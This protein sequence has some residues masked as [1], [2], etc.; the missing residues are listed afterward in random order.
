MTVFTSCITS[1]LAPYVP[2]TENPWN[3]VR[4]RHAF[5]RI[6]YDANR[7]MI[8]NALT[9][10]PSLFIDQLINESLN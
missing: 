9:T 5:R 2:S 3:E 1:S 4:V 10:D 6:G 8:D 7:S